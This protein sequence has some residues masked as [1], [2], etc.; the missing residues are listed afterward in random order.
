ME[1]HQAKVDRRG[2]VVIPAEYRRTLGVAPGDSV[3]LEL[4]EGVL[5]IQTRAAA[6]R[7]AQA[8][9][10]KHTAGN[11]SLVDELTAERRSEAAGG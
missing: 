1:F 6:I 7:R 2:R 10:T 5:R 9:V 8:L 11:G 4:G 3:V